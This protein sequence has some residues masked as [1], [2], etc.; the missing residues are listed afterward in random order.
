MALHDT[1]GRL[2]AMW[3]SHHYPEDY[4]RCVVV[5]RSH[6][7]RRCLV[8]YP[9]AF[10]VMALVLALPTRSSVVEAAVVVVAPL[11][12]VIEF[13]V[14]HIGRITYSPSRQIIVTI[15]LA[16]GLGVGFAVYLRKPTS[17][18][19]WGVVA[20]Y[21][22][23]CLAAVLLGARRSGQADANNKM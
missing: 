16:L 5:G 14:E 10:V 9:S 12:A 2:T 6:V 17:L 15:P 21:G 13:V 19:F 7:C 3:L 8:L 1:G 11:P 20:L 22:G 4:D 23:V 18:L